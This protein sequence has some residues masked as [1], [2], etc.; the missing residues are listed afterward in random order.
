[1]GKL[2]KKDKFF[3]EELG[4]RIVEI[5]KEKGLSQVALGFK[6][7]IEKPS[8]NRIEKGGT[9]PTI[10]TLKKI[11]DALGIELQELFAG[12]DQPGAIEPPQS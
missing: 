12:M 1:M 9:N 4:R 2:N 6:I 5:R 10:L 7:D 11:C 8:M 3:L